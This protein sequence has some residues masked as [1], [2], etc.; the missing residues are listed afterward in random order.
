MNEPLLVTRERTLLRDLIQ[1][2][3]AR[4]R[5]EKLLGQ[6]APHAKAQAESAAEAARKEAETWLQSEQAAIE[7]ETEESRAA[8]QARYDREQAAAEAEFDTSQEEMNN[9]FEEEKEA[10]RDAHKE[11][12]WTINAVLE[13]NTINAEERRRNT[14]AKL[15]A[16]LGQLTVFRRE[17]NDLWEE[18]ERYLASAPKSSAGPRDQN[19]RLSLRK[20][21]NALHEKLAG[22]KSDLTNLKLPKALKGGRLTLAFAALGL[23]MVYP[24]GWL[25]T[26]FGGFPNQ[27][28][29]VLIAGLIAASVTAVAAGMIVNGVL[30]F[31][32]RRQVRE[33]FRIYPGMCLAADSVAARCRQR[34]KDSAARYPRTIVSLKKRHKRTLR[35]A[36]REGRLA[37]RAAKQRLNEALPAATEQYHQRKEDADAQLEADLLTLDHERERRL[38]ES[39]QVHDAAVDELETTYRRRMEEIQG[40]YD[41]VWQMAAK[42]WRHATAELRE[43]L[44]AIWEE[45]GSL[46][47]PWDDSCWADRP[48][49]A[50]VPPALQFG[51]FHVGKEQIPEIVP[52]EEKL[53]PEAVEDFVLPAVCAFPDKASMLFLAQDAGRA[54]AVEA[55]QDVLY[56]LLT[57]IPPGKVR[58]TIIDPVGLGQNFAAF[59]DLADH[60]ELLVSSRIW[61]EVGHIEQRMA[62]LTAHMENVIQKYLRDRYPTIGDYN[63]MAGE[64]AEPFRI[65]VVANFPTNF[66]PDAARR[67]VSIAQNG[68]RCGVLTLITVDRKQ[69]MPDGFDLNDLKRAGVRL[70]WDAGKFVWD[71]ED[72]NRFPLTLEAPPDAALGAMILDQVGRLSR[73]ARRVEVPFEFIAPPPEQW[74]T[75]DSKAGLSVALGRSGATSRQML[76]LGQGTAQHVLIAGK[77]GSGKSTLLH[78]LI[79][80]LALLYSPDEVELY[81]VDFKKGVE[82]KAYA[83]HGLPHAR[84]IAVE[85]EREFGLSVLQRLDAEMKVRGEAYR[86]VGAQDLNSYRLAEPEVRCPR[87]MLIVDEFQEF[88]TE[89]DRIAQDAAQLLD[90]LVRQGRAFGLHVLLGSQTLGGAYSLARSTVDQMAIRIALQCSEADA[91][92]ILSADNSAARLLTRPGEAIYNDANGLVE[93][94]NPFQVVWLS[95]ERREEYLNQIRDMAVQQE[96]QAPAPVIFEGNAPAD[97]ADNHLLHHLL[98]EAAAPDGEA[99]AANASPRAWLGDA[100]AINDLT[101]AFFRRQNGSNLLVVGQQDPMALGVLTS[102][103][104]SL[105]AQAPAARFT[106]IDARQSE[107]PTTGVWP[108]LP[109]VLSQTVRL[110]GWR[111]VPSVMGEMAAEMERRQKEPDADAPPLYL[112]IYGLQRCRDLRRREDDFSFGRTADEPANP[113]KQFADLLREGASLGI[114]LLIWCD[115]YTNL[116]R[117][118]DRAGLRE[119]ALRVVFQMSVADSSNLIDNPLAA[120]LGVHRALFSSEEDGRLEKFRPYGLP[121]DE[122][123]AWV[124]GQLRGRAAPVGGAV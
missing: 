37:V 71:D 15:T 51:Q 122:W 88:F 48:P 110:A 70:T 29:L 90:R 120:K 26:Y 40:G 115:T 13:R 83:A 7:Q 38:V 93:G 74:W 106:L 86:A 77:T 61:T 53:A 72:F 92:L 25:V 47:P 85:S 124:K 45:S 3:A 35:Q 59:M 58:F 99:V 52:E 32:I 22:L 20:S 98:S 94:N 42:A 117:A 10:A 100:L 43:T 24:L 27:L 1:R 60:D 57:C 82:F 97:I 4:A 118:V 108:Q 91:Q 95:D 44:E 30:E 33:L 96:S 69:P 107:A 12:Q 50:A 111:N 5:D 66:T 62:D 76:R 19:P 67:L 75:G 68:P 103:V 113:S 81:L 119:L 31:M 2:A 109:D 123:L 14:E 11:A 21:L 80:N 34:M 116:Q 6:T 49:S 8:I 41:R 101:A 121:S 16:I 89:D 65:L 63:A 87:I 102:A 36:K 112:V 104:I 56:R 79:T 17:A 105:A 46:F 78:A 84:V 114:H 18:W 64:V 54:K 39:Q 73:A 28:P 23:L 9:R 55:L